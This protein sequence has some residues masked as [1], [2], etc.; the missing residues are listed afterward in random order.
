MKKITILL[1]IIIA[2]GFISSCTDD[3]TKINKNPNAVTKEEASAKYFITNPQFELYAPNRY[4]YWRAH[5]IHMDRY[6]GQVC[7]GNHQIWWS[8]ELGYAY[9]SGYTDATWDWLAGYLGQLDNFMRL[10]DTGGDFENNLMYATGLI[11]KGLYFQM[12]TDVFGDIPYSEAADP[13]ITLPKF[14]AQKDI[15]KGIIADLDKAMQIIGDNERTGDGVQDLGENDLYCNGDLQK[16]KRMANSLKLRIATRAYGATGDDFANAAIT[17]ALSSPLLEGE[18]D[19]VLLIK[20]EQISQWGSACY[21]DVW[22]CCGPDGGSGWRLSKTL[23]DYLR[24]NNDPRLALYAQPA[25]G[26]TFMFTRP[27]PADNQ[28]GY[29]HFFE[30]MHFLRDVIADAIGNTNFYTEYAADSAQFDIPANTYYIG[31]PTRLNADIKPYVRAEFWSK[32]SEWVYQQKNQGVKPFP[33]LI[34]TSGETAL[35]RAEAIVNGLA[36]GDANQYYQ[37]GI[38]QEMKIWGVDDAAIQEYLDNSPW[39]SITGLSTDQ[40]L[41]RIAV[42]RWIGKY[43]DGFEAW[44]IVR[45]TGYPSELS[46]GVQDPIL[47][48]LGDINGDYPTRMR[49]GSAAYNTN[50]TNLQQALSRQGADVQNTKLWWQK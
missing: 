42:Q 50:G 35:L 19:N 36:S 5:L 17:S 14:D 39:G 10:T 8:D 9:H 49:Y 47:Y 31:Q 29:D 28:D 3:F 45:K 33:E 27:D 30:R 34:I 2:L 41:E 48:G 23:I 15:Y 26:G 32:P 43:T 18:S 16:W 6:S 21:G 22:Y 40:Q 44:A 1:G 24:D 38:R 46:Q 7:F 20:D 12:F 37:E 4:P 25:E 11:M 13:D